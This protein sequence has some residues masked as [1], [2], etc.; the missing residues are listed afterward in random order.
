MDMIRFLV[1]KKANIDK[2]TR[3][4]YVVSNKHT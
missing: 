2:P 1:K 4:G 3:D